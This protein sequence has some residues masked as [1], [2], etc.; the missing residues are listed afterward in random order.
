MKTSS[1]LFSLLGLLA[2]T[3]I[4][5]SCDDE[6]D[7][8]I[9]DDEIVMMD[10][11]EG[12]CATAPVSESW[13]TAHYY[14]PNVFTPNAD[15]INDLFGIFTGDGI[16]QIDSFR[17][18]DMEG[19]MLFEQF[20]FGPNNVIHFWS[21]TNANNTLHRGAFTY[22]AVLRNTAG[23]TKVVNGNGCVLLCIDGEDT[24]NIPSA[25]CY[26]P[27]QH[28]GE[29]ELDIHFPSMDADCF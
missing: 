8:V 15:G 11:Y 4:L 29:G 2:L 22:Q 7:D 25:D 13:D 9:V 23:D 20:S 16:S 3:S 24:S 18:W 5:Y 14:I 27:V 17:V 1:I 21:G 10:P 28:N 6:E 12:C 19:N 26:F